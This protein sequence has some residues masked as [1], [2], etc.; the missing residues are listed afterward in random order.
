MLELGDQRPHHRKRRGLFAALLFGKQFR[1][2]PQLTLEDPAF[3]GDALPV[4]MF[5]EHRLQNLIED[6]PAFA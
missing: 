2:R 4:R 6:L 3:V 5:L 1:K